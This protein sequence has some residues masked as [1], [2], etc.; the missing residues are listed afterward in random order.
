MSV[1][2]YYTYSTKHYQ[3]SESN[4][5]DLELHTT[6]IHTNMHMYIVICIH[7]SI[8]INVANLT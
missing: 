1:Y 2:T 3:I 7:M 8:H 4:E 6:Y 5:S